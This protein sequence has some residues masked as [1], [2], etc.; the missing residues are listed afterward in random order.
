[1]CGRLKRVEAGADDE[2]VTIPRGRYLIALALTALIALTFTGYQV[3]GHLRDQSHQREMV[4]ARAALAALTWP[5]PL[6]RTSGDRNCHPTPNDLCL[7]TPDRPQAVVVQMIK[8]MQVDPAAVRRGP[9]TRSVPRLSSFTAKIV[10]TSRPIVVTVAATL[11][12]A[13]PGSKERIAV[14]GS[15]VLIG[16][17]G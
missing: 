2:P 12:I 13:P 10:G 3:A 11:E 1:M 4:R 17:V 6:R 5:E 14:T 16:L 15:R 7:L 8:L 9:D